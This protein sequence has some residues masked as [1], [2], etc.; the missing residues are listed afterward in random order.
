MMPE[1]KYKIRYILLLLTL[2]VS[3]N[4]FSQKEYELS[5]WI[6]GINDEPIKNVTISVLGSSE[7]PAVSD[8]EGRYSIKVKS[9]YVWITFQPIGMWESKKVFLDSRKTLNVY[10]TL[11]DFT[12]YNQLVV[13]EGISKLSR[14]V[15]SAHQN[16]SSRQMKYSDN[17]TV[18]Q[19]F[20]TQLTGAIVN[21]QSGMPG[22]GTSTFLRG[23]STVNTTN[24][25]LYVVDGIPME[26]SSYYE[27]YFEGYNYNPITSIDPF[28]VSS[29]TVY[30]DP[31]YTSKYGFYGA[32]GV[33]E[34]HTISPDAIETSIDVKYRTGIELKPDY[35][36]QL[37]SQQYKM[38]AN[39]LLYSSGMPQEEYTLAY[40]GLFYTAKDSVN[41]VPY[42]N[43]TNWQDEVFQ[44]TLMQ[45]F[46]FSIKGGDAIAK[47]GISVGF[48][49]KDGI[50]K[51]TSYNRFNA[52]FAGTFNIIDRIKMGLNVS[53][54]NAN[55]NLR[56]SG[57]STVTSPIISGLWKSPLLSPYAY[58]EQGVML[59]STADL[60]ALGVSNP[61]ALNR[62]FTGDNSNTRF[63]TSA[64]IIGELSDKVNLVSLLAVN[65]N[66]TT[67][68]SF[69]PDLGMAAYSNGETSNE[70]SG[71]VNTYWGIYSN[72]YLNYYDAWGPNKLHRFS[73]NLGMRYNYVD[74][75]NDYAKTG[76]TPSDAY[77]SL[78]LGQ[79]IYDFVGGNAINY[80]WLSFNGNLSYDYKTKYLLNFNLT[81]DASTSIGHDAAT[82]F[83]IGNVPMGL[84]YSVGAAWRISNES[85]M[86]NLSWFDDVKLRM[87]YGTAG[88]DNFSVLASQPYYM[89]DHFNKLGVS[90]P[91]SLANTSLTY[92]KTTTLN[93]GLDLVFKGGKHQIIVDWYNSIVDNMLVYIPLPNF[94]GESV[95][96]SN[97]GKVSTKGI[98][99]TFNTRIIDHRDFK[100]DLGIGLGHNQSKI[101]EI[102]GDQIVRD[103]PGNGQVVLRKGDELMSFYGYQFNG[104]FATSQESMAANLRNDK[105]SLYRAGDAI[106]SDVSGKQG[107]PDQ[108]INSYDR[109]SIGSPAPAMTGIFT[110]TISYKKWML[111]SIS[112]FMIGQEVFN[113]VRYQN[114]KMTDLSNQSVKVLQRWVSE[115]QQT[116]VPKASWNDPVGN[117]DFS[118]RWIE[119]GSYF[120][121]KE[122]TLAYRINKSFLFVKNME[123]YVTVKNV[124]TLTNYTGYDPEFSYSSSPL[125][126]GIDY[127][128][129]PQTRSFDFGVNI[130]L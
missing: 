125:L 49:S 81:T 127:G 19:F 56:E 54:T 24:Q 47:Y 20:Q 14:D 52:R 102:P 92:E 11:K 112:Q 123:A 89:T 109:V 70:V 2:C 106:Y 61:L 41:Y 39:E 99:F 37:Q 50:I 31:S 3:T 16:I 86:K 110:T 44:N 18:D 30:K 12:S 85:F 55:M 90:V 48:L 77:T 27:S 79:D 36:P 103:I 67:E 96:P 40:P 116:D 68:N 5:G 88:N 107:V 113:Y 117:S 119:D 35:M 101:L 7:K 115:G 51:N 74:F 10:L 111:R 38:L 91:G 118:S 33:V 122:L 1:M 130:G 94:V 69:S 43:N 82:P 34:I 97:G 121:L 21:N 78:G 124:L 98:E 100:I 8:D 80:G 58:D 84:F 95:F 120:R 66:T 23:I 75:Q 126:Q 46:Y 65:Y 26:R 73:A 63:S 22:S 59:N 29:I 60:D 9:G 45:N 76:S 32:N 71:F 6:K 128:S 25:P 72:T 108:T 62:G 57:L 28:D 93:T 53:L 83:N 13:G 15:I 105:A 129:T 42:S 17:I 114:E 87:S 4:A 64:K 104:V